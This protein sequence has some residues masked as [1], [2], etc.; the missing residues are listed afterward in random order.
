[1]HARSAFE[2]KRRMCGGYSKLPFA[3][4]LIRWR[5]DQSV[6]NR[7]DFVSRYWN[8]NFSREEVLKRII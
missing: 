3:P 7:D 5:A 1:M 8:T 2:G 4:F 6:V